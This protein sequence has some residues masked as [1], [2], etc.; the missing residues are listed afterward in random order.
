MAG[1]LG[2]N[3]KGAAVSGNTLATVPSETQE[4]LVYA[5]SRVPV[6]LADARFE[7]FSERMVRYVVKLGED[8]TPE[9][10]EKWRPLQEELLAFIDQLRGELD[11]RK[12]I[13]R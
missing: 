11:Q 2:Q 8:R 9:R 13:L 3:S 6:V 5:S 4:R 7:S 10:L 1:V 12:G